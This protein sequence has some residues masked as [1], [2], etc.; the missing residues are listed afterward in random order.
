M[1]TIQL[2]LLTLMAA[3]L[4]AR[5]D[6]EVRLS[7]KFILNA[8]G[9][10]PT[11][12]SD[13]DL[14][15][16]TAF[17]AE[18]THGNATLAA[19]GRGYRLRVVEYLN[20][21]PPSPAAAT[22]SITGGITSGSATV[23]CSN[24]AGLQTWM[25]VLGAGVPANTVVLGINPNTS[26]T[27][28]NNALYTA[29]SEWYS[30]SFP[31][32]HWYQVPARSAREYI[33]AAA[34]AAQTTWRW[35]P[36]AI[37][38]YVNNSRS[39]SCSF[40]GNGLSI[41]MGSTIFTRG[42]VNHEIGHFFNLSHTHNGDPVFAG[43]VAPTPLSSGLSNGDG[44]TETLPDHPF[45]NIDQLSVG[46]FGGN[47][48]ALTAGQRPAVDDTFYN[49]MSYHLED[50][51][52]DIQ[53]DHWAWNANIHRKFACSGYTV[54]VAPFGSN[55]SGAPLDGGLNAN[56]PLATMDA[57]LF[58]TA[59]RTSPDDVVLLRS[60]NYMAPATQMTTPC[61]LRAERG[62]VTLTR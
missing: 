53:M 30:G 43:W 38:I 57:A 11:N 61:T 15:T 51:F 56:A 32:D 4:P 42:T 33:E 20:I 47:Y 54:F 6:I 34:L 16:S 52:L 2:L 49:V 41:A 24:T 29:P 9:A 62:P 59:R 40:V 5:A 7:V 10:A 45:Y 37:N 60:G 12:S 8:G 35:N 27:I 22:V 44:L 18:I 50:R 23:T 39:G 26:F 25:R 13:I 3:A 58:Y 55:P 36:S 1:K 48:A 46:N 17:D 19:T 14:S 21:Q 31:A 28:S